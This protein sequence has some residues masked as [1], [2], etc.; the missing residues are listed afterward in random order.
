MQ[1]LVADMVQEDPAKRPPIEEVELR[2]EESVGTLSRWK[3]RSRL[4]GKKEHVLVRTIY[5]IGHIVRTV[6]YLAKRLPPVPSPSS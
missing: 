6:K 3:L 5:A 1:Q 2:F 4:I